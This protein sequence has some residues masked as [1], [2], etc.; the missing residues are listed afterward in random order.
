VCVS[1]LWLVSCVLSWPRASRQWTRM[2]FRITYITIHIYY[3]NIISSCTYCTFI[4]IYKSEPR[5]RRASVQGRRKRPSAGQRVSPPPNGCR[6]PDNGIWTPPC[7]RVGILKS[8]LD[9]ILYYYYNMYMRAAVPKSVCIHCSCTGLYIVYIHR[10]SRLL[11]RW[12]LPTT[13]RISYTFIPTSVEYTHR[14]MGSC[15]TESFSSR[16]KAKC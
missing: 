8:L 4:Y 15:S 1:R 16:S 2:M 10:G 13:M 5:L 12:T 6:R 9:V 7:M 14:G 11:R 3:N